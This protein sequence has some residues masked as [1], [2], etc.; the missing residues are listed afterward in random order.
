MFRW[1]V[2]TACDLAQPIRDRD[3]PVIH[4]GGLTAAEASGLGHFGRHRG[5]ANPISGATSGTRKDAYWLKSLHQ[6]GLY[7][8]LELDYG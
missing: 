3:P 6:Q 2:P 1:Q 7:T 8:E 5:R 4:Q